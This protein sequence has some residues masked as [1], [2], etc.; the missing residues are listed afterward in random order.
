MWSLEATAETKPTVKRR[1]YQISLNILCRSSFHE[2]E[3]AHVKRHTVAN[4]CV[5]YA[6]SILHLGNTSFLISGLILFFPLHAENSN[7]FS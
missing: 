4:Q 2:R 3:S 1:S 7:V 6:V 5:V